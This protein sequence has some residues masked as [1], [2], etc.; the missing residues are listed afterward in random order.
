MD[1]KKLNLKRFI[2]YKRFW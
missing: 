2:N 1:E